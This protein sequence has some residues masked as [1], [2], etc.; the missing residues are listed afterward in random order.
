MNTRKTAEFFVHASA[1]CESQHI[2]SGTRI[3]AFSHVLDRARIGS[4]CN[5]G[6][7][8]Y[9]ESGAN[10][11]DRVVVKNGVQVWDGV[12]IDD[13]AF[14]GPAV[15]FTN[16][17]TPRSRGL[18]Q[19]MSRYSHPE[20][21]RLST[22]IE[23]GASIGAGAVI[24]PGLTIG[25]YAMIGAGSVVNRDVPPHRLVAGNPARA[26]GWVCACGGRLTDNLL[27][28]IC[29]RSFALDDGELVVKVNL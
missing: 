14:I 8:C 22:R 16:D 15:C 19:A 11:G 2:G 28:T 3:W 25:A 21:W 13:E 10:I 1:L 4:R 7:H 27:C 26:I 23:R 12:T 6:E 20:N 9:I 29:E 5:I 17:M 24:L 18:T